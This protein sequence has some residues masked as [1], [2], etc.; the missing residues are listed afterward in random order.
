MGDRIQIGSFSGDVIDI[1]VFKFALMEIGHWVHADQS[2]GR[3]LHIPNSRV[4]LEPLANYTEEFD[5]IWD[6]IPITVTF[7]SHWER[8]KQLLGEIAARHSASQDLVAGEIDRQKSHKYYYYYTHLTST[9]YT[10]LRDNG[11]CLTLRYLCRTRERRAV[12]Q[13]M[14]ED[15]LEAFNERDDIQF[16]Y[17]TRRT[18]V[19]LKDETFK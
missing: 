10:S 2:T 15:I 13:A 16:A 18:L 11:V 1:N 4:F 5:F 12:H 8:A 9:V 14:I 3:I 19:D 7:E 6:E 17:V